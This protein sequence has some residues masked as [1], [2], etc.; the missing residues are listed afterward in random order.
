MPVTLQEGSRWENG[1]AIPGD[2]GGALRKDTRV[3]SLHTGKMKSPGQPKVWP[4]TQAMPGKRSQTEAGIKWRGIKW[5]KGR[6]LFNHDTKLETPRE[7]HRGEL[8][9]TQGRR[10]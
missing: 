10:Y 4:Q 7:N 1:E 3:S 2:L 6:K 9:L 8:R 5:E